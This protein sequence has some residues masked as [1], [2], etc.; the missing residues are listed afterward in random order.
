VLSADLRPI[1]TIAGPLLAAAA[2]DSV[3]VLSAGDEQVPVL[4]LTTLA[5][6]GREADVVEAGRVGLAAPAQAG[7]LARRAGR[8]SN[9]R[10]PAPHAV[11]AGDALH[12]AVP[13]RGRGGTAAQR[14]GAAGP[15]GLGEVATLNGPDWL[16]AHAP[17]GDGRRLTLTGAGPVVL[18]LGEAQLASWPPG[19]R[20]RLD[21]HD[22]EPPWIVAARRA[23]WEALRLDGDD[24]AAVRPG[25]GA[26]EVA[27]AVADGLWLVCE[28]GGARRLIRVGPGGELERV[29]A[30]DAPLEPIGRAGGEILALAGPRGAPRAL[31]AIEPD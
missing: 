4:T 5:V 6:A 2:G 29:A 27:L 14:V 1:T 9:P 8:P 15:S 28:S 31:V 24:V 18:W 13:A 23:R 11:V 7:R 22:G 30:L 25:D 26:V 16:V 10:P 19:V 20:V 21:A 17:T 12:F 3:W